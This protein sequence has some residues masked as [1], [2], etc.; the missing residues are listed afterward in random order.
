M[1]CNRATSNR[2]EV[3]NLQL[4]RVCG[5]KLFSLARGLEYNAR[6]CKTDNI[7][8]TCENG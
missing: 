7:E 2:G 6:A 3:S 8:I 1:G 4:K 5:K